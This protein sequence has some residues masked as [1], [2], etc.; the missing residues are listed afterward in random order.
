MLPKPAHL[1][2]YLST[3]QKQAAVAGLCKVLKYKVNTFYPSSDE[4]GAGGIVVAS[5]VWP[6]IRPASGFQHFVSGAELGNPGM[7]FFN[8]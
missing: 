1:I 7:D 5:D 3:L 4:V 6:A 8:F 2:F